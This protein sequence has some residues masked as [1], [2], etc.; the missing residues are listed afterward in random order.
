MNLPP[1]NGDT[2]DLNGDD[3]AN[4]S[5]GVKFSDEHEPRQAARF[6]PNK[7]HTG[8]K[9]ISFNVGAAVM[10]SN[11]MQFDQEQPESFGIVK[12]GKPIGKLSPNADN[13]DALSPV[14]SERLTDQGYMDLKFYHNKLW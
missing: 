8:L 2:V 12:I 4:R 7:K 10:P 3:S 9:N 14:N 13:T 1:A 11:K 5:R 6:Q